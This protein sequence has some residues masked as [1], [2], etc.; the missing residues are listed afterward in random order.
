MPGPRERSPLLGDSRDSTSSLMS[1]NDSNGAVINPRA[2]LTH[3]QSDARRALRKLRCAAVL[4]FVFMGGEVY[5]GYMANSLAIMTDAA[6][7]LSDVAGLLISMFSLWLSTKPPSSKHTFG[8]HRIEIIGAL[9]GVM[10]IWALTG[11]LVYEAVNRVRTPQDVDGKIMFITACCGLCVNIGM[12]NILHQGG[13]G[14]SHGGGGGG[15][16]HSHGGG[17]GGGG[18]KRR[19]SQTHP[20][21]LELETAA[22]SL[23]VKAAFIHAVGDMIQSLGVVIAGALLWWRPQYHIADPICTFVFSGLVLWSTMSLIWQAFAVLLNTVPAGIDTQELLQ[24]VSRVDGVMDVH[25][26]HVWSI[27]ASRA[28][29]SVHLV[30]RHPQATLKAAQLICRKFGIRHTTIQV[31]KWGSSDVDNCL[32]TNLVCT[33]GRETSALLDERIASGQ[34]AGGAHDHDHGHGGHHHD[35]DH[36]DGHDDHHDHDGAHEGEHGH[37]HEHGHG[38]GHGHAHAHAG[39]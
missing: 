1:L 4:C 30:S 14:H 21:Q 10:L 12:M 28:S 3:E 19:G 33:V 24:Q 22:E 16:G 15:H 18:D 23:S 26:F 27:A 34:I 32:S 35:D 37:S 5:G 13:H 7:L 6:H 25:D 9:A 2:V 31:E 8:F 20:T 17:D 39:V 36:V 29:L 38:H 11:V